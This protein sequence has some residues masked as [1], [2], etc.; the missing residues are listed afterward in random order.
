MDDAVELLNNADTQVDKGH[1]VTLV[2]PLEVCVDSVKCVVVAVRV[3]EL[4]AA[5]EAQLV[6]VEAQLLQGLL[7]RH[8]LQALRSGKK[9]R[10]RQIIECPSVDN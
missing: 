4:H 8:Q 3:L 1:P 6:F 9:T 7:R 2:S 5:G 10:R